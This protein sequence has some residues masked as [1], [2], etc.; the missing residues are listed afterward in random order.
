MSRKSSSTTN[1]KE[2]KKTEARFETSQRIEKNLNLR[3]NSTDVATRSSVRTKRI[4]N[5]VKPMTVRQL[6]IDFTPLHQ[7]SFPGRKLFGVGG[8]LGW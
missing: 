1:R 7:G 5:K 6:Q 8:Q 4:R 3:L 2:A